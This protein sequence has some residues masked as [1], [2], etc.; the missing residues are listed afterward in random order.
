MSEAPPGAPRSV[1][2]GRVMAGPA[3]LAP[4][5]ATLSVIAQV[6]SGEAEVGVLALVALAGFAAT[7]I[8]GVLPAGLVAALLLEIDRRR[9]RPPRW[10]WLYT[11]VVFLSSAGMLGLLA[12]GI[13]ELDREVL[14]GLG[15]AALTLGSLL[16]HGLAKRAQMRADF[17]RSDDGS[18]FRALRL[19]DGSLALRREAALRQ[20]C[21]GHLLIA[22]P[23]GAFG[24]TELAGEMRG[25]PWSW[26]FFTI[27]LVILALPSCF[28]A[29][30]VLLLD[31]R[32]GAR[33]AMDWI[34]V[35]LV[36]LLLAALLTSEPLNLSWTEAALPALYSLVSMLLAQLLILRAR[37][38]FGSQAGV[39]EPT[40]T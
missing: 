7:M 23:G 16:G 6:S 3:L 17:R 38:R 40:A 34:R 35:P 27:S 24:L 15:G 12:S 32:R 4:L 9:G 22:I 39:R 21:L 31:G 36:P 2:V 11:L 30:L 20:I 18:S 33:P 14:G 28:L 1:I 26:L 19:T 5:V 29:G 25:G 37:R 8:F 13:D 10:D